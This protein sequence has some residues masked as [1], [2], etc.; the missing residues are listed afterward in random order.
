MFGKPAGEG[1]LSEAP[2]D[3][4][5]EREQLD[6]MVEVAV[7]NAGAEE[8]AQIRDI[9]R[10]LTDD[11]D[12]VFESSAVD[13]CTRA[14]N[15]DPGQVVAADNSTEMQELNAQQ[16]SNTSDLDDQP[17]TRRQ[18]NTQRF[19]ALFGG[20]GGL[21]GAGAM[22]YEIIKSE[23]TKCDDGDVPLPDEIKKKIKALV[24][25]WWFVP[26]PDFW[27][28]FATAVS[29]KTAP[30]TVQDQILFTSYV[31][32]LAGPSNLIWAT[33]TDQETLVNALYDAYK[34]SGY[35]TG[36][37]YRAVIP[38]TYQG[39]ALQRGVA[40]T[41][42]RYALLKALITDPGAT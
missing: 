18:W 41:L 21:A 24:K 6:E 32:D 5:E 10:S 38:M 1:E 2:K 4:E 33:S 13:L 20:V 40:A 25:T 29:D 11:L 23:T 35:E 7:R 19:I 22:L 42:L 28:R 8:A 27:N 37:M 17:S 30:L 14:G 3:K 31:I 15:V 26:D 16:A 9:N 36:P 39:K 34:T 12:A